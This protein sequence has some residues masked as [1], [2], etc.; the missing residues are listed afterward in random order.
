MANIL[1]VIIDGDSSKFNRSLQ[2]AQKN[3][4]GF[5]RN[6]RDIGKSLSLQ[7]TAPLG[8][9]AGAALKSAANFEKLRTQL[10]TLTGSAENGAKAF[11]R[12]V[13]FSAQTPFQLDELAKVN[14]LL[15]GFGLNADEAYE[16]VGLLG[17]VA[18]VAGGDLQNIGV[19]F[20][21]AAASGRLMA[22]DINQFIN[23]GVPVIKLLADSMGVAEGEIK[24]LASAGQVTFPEL[25]RALQ[26]ATSEGGMFEGGMQKLSTTFN[27]LASTLKDNLNIALAELGNEIITA[28]DLKGLMTNFINFIKNLTDRFKKLD[29]QVKKVALQVGLFAAAFPPLLVVI[30]TILIPMGK[31]FGALG[32][33]IKSVKVAMTALNTAMKANPV[34]LITS[35][36]IA[37]GTALIEVLH[38]INPMVSRLTTLFNVIKS[39]G[40]PTKFMALQ[41]QSSADALKNQNKE[42]EKTKASTDKLNETLKETGKALDLIVQKGGGAPAAA[43]RAAVSTVSAISL[44]KSKGQGAGTAKAGAGGDIAVGLQ[45][46]STLA[47]Q[48]GNIGA[49]LKESLNKTSEDIGIAF[50]DI[51]DS[52]V[53]GLSG[54]IGG[55]ASGSMNMAQA[56]QALL[57]VI[58]GIAVQLGKAALKIGAGMLAIKQS[59]KNPA[60]AI[61]AGVALIAIGAAIQNAGNI[62]KG[63]G[64]SGGG[65]GIQRFANGGII[66]A[67]TLGLMGEYSGVR[68]NPEVVAPLNKLKGMIGQGGTNVNV[69]GGFRLEGQDLVVALQRA[70]RNRNRL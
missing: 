10:D 21:Q 42:T 17:D 61:A 70:E 53:N 2:T 3:L 27:G 20:G 34:I 63:G 47:P 7:L 58:G 19:A 31:A 36:V 48:A 16:S 60:T 13:K 44:S 6:V 25:I 15:L 66:S 32:V 46:L 68:S 9:A 67:P 59:F 22:Q 55:L 56:G 33:V 64:G 18:A 11:D 29:P 8:L 49:A 30:G 5:G 37:L 45:K 57:G 65:S 23:N 54:A 69:T 35:A 41:A 50:I 39:G 14:N 24:K 12:L 62:P 38:S 4:T 26:K 28:F 1:E 43:G 40:S 51:T 52:V